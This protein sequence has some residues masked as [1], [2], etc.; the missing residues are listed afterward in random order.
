MLELSDF[1]C[2]VSHKASKVAPNYRPLGLQ[3]GY[4]ILDIRD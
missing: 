3:A 1:A 2:K 4:E